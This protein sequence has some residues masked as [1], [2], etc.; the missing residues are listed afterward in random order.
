M[1]S[2]ETHRPGGPDEAA[3]APPTGLRHA[4]RAFRNRDFAI[5]WWGALA[6]NTG[7]W[8]KNLAV[9]FVLYELTSSALWVGLA[10]FAQFVPAMVLGPLAG[11]IADRFDRRRVLLVTQGMQ[12]L[13][14][15][16]LWLGW[17][18]GV[19]S[20][21][22]ILALVALSGVFNGLNVP[23]WQSFVNDLVPRRDLLSA[24]TLNSVQFHLARAVGPAIAGLLLAT[25]GATW[26]FFLNAVSFVFVLGALLL[27]RARPRT[28]PPMGKGVLRQFGRA[29]RYVRGQPGIVAGV[30]VAVLVAFLG[31][32]IFQFTVVFAAEVF[33]VGP[34]G[35]SLL[36]VALGVGAVLAAPV[37]SGWDSVVSR[38]AVVRWSLLCYGVALVVF[39]TSPGY[40][41][42]VVALVVMGGGFL[43]VISTVNTAVQT[44]V[45]DHL[46]GRVI[47]LRTVAFT[48]AYP[49]GALVQGWLSDAFGPRVTVAGAGLVLL[50]CGAWLGWRSG[51]LARL[52]DPHDDRAPGEPAGP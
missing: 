23:S 2:R 36:N 33:V 29:L 16:A 38:A 27:V 50:A 40:A 43:A 12:A 51:L 20:P 42:G 13:A 18:L 19:R 26:A 21:G 52:D 46:R 45:A 37:V 41:V 9:P 11:S 7:V 15:A 32:P 6:S 49:F 48:G 5:F 35:L 31:N 34:I 1:T 24:V 4:V 10:T 14:T 30:V 22:A 39:A 28:R 44:I 8:V 25:L 17:A 3:A 47:A